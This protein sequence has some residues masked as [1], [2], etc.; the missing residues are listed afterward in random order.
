MAV[1]YALEH[2]DSG[3]AYIGSTA[4]KT[5]KRLREHRCL[6][7][8]GKH[9]SAKLQQDWDAFGETAFRLRILE[10]LGHNASFERKKSAEQ[11]WL[12]R[13]DASGKLYNAY[14][15]AYSM[16]IETVLMGTAVAH[17]EPGNRWTPEVNERRRLAQLGKPKGHGAKISATKRAKREAERL[18][19]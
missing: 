14:R 5:S 2:I 12:D 13:Y 6:L 19:R 15:V 7:R 4:S 11:L 18:M 8:N 17:R 16:P 1:I 10:D 9:T 3:Q